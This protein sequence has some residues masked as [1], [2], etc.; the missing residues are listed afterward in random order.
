MS[1]LNQ[2]SAVQQEAVVYRDGPQL[3]I[4]GAGSGKTR[5]LTHKIAYLLQQGME[6]WAVLALTF[7]N[8]AAREMKERIAM[9]VGE[10]RSRYLNMGTFHSVFSHIL[11]MESETIGY[12]R[13]FTIYDQSD[14]RALV[15]TIIKELGLDEKQYQPASVTD[16]ISRVKNHLIRPKDYA[17]NTQLIHAD[18]QR[19]QDRLLDIYRSYVE[20]CRRAN[21]MD[22]DDLL[23]YTYQLF[24]EH[25]EVRQKYARRYQYVLVDEYQ[26]TNRVQQ[27]ILWQ[28]T[29]DRQQLCV[30]GDD[31]Q[32]IYSFRGAM[33]DNILNFTQQYH[34]AKV[35]K[36]E[37]NYRS[38]RAIVNAANSLIKHNARQI[39][40]QVFSNKEEGE[41]LRLYHTKTDKEEALVVMK[42]IEHRHRLG[43]SY[44]D[45]AILYRTNSQSRTFEECFRKQGI[46]YRIYGGLSFYQRKEIKDIIAYF[47]LVI[48]PDDEEAF[49][50]IINYPT[51]GIGNTTL[52][53]IADAAHQ[54]EV[55]LWEV[56]SHLTFYQL[57]LSPATVK[58]VEAFRVMIEEFAQRVE[59]EDAYQ[60]GK[61]IVRQSGISKEIFSG[62]D[63]EALSR[64]ANVDEFM[65]ALSDF[66]AQ[67]KEEDELA[68]A[69]LAAFLQEVALLTDQDAALD[70][71]EG[72]KLVMMTIH[73]AKGLE[74]PI[75]FVVGV[76]ENVFPSPRAIDSMRA[77]EE[78]R[79]LLYVAITRAEKVCVLTCAQMRFRFGRMEY[80]EPSRFLK[81]FPPG[82][83]KETRG[84]SMSFA[85][86]TRRVSAST[87]TYKK[88]SP[89]PSVSSSTPQPVPVVSSPLQGKRIKHDRFG[90]G[91]VIAVVGE[92]ENAK[93]T[94]MFEQAGTKQLLLKFARFTVL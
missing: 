92:G 12:D 63:T 36:L 13:Q 44:D 79:R 65:S 20:R 51:R 25:E 5:V 50:R 74:F 9:L 80:D 91:E 1:D 64:Q 43:T 42:E 41:P 86:E 52:T 66:V 84:S 18:A 26:D 56:I 31:A 78:E 48:N 59:T 53:R 87:P 2:L 4:A 57:K 23:V 54:H 27:A 15:K 3:V 58:K 90:I 71:E 8:K 89:L 81:D 39:P 30:V 7:T 93:A 11:R 24:E 73:S 45:M 49:R 68:H 37:Q 61:D 21:A 10:E 47:R 19:H 67:K 6:P 17:L 62:T 60:L 35:F 75:V 33:I 77:L 82:M 16:Q 38:T 14:S 55:S 22:F 94:V 32:S 46:P 28:L 72:P 69:S 40:K 29:R 83:L 70:D 85:M 88:F 34:Q 76:E